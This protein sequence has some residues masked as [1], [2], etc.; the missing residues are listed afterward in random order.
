[1]FEKILLP[2]DGSAMAERSI[3]HA[4]E[5]AR[6][7]N[8]KILI[9][10]ILKSETSTES[11]V[12]T[13]PLNWQLHKAKTELYLHKT[14]NEMRLSLGLPELDAESD[15]ESRVTVTVLE[16]KVAEN[17]VDFAQKENIDLLIISSHGS[18]GLSRWNL[19]SVTTKVVNL[20]YK[21]VLIIRG[22]A[23]DGDD[24]IHPRYERIML[25]LDCSR[26][27]E[28]SLNAGL[29]L[30]KNYQ[31]RVILSSV[32]KPPEIS[33]IDPYNQELQLLNQQYMDLSRK[34]VQS[35]MD[36]LSQRLGVGNEIRIV[37]DH[38]IVRAIMR[39]ADDENVDL[40]ILCAHGFTG[41]LSWPF[42][43]VARS[44][45]EYSTK[46]V[47]VIQD[48]TH[49]DVLPTDASQAIESTRSPE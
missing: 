19:N 39:L 7:F 29:T 17:I 33:A 18:S 16:G 13:E 34:T 40:L 46:P 15:G 44:F 24:P 1:M 38:S 42:G 26:R 30:A 10:Q 43:T 6:I 45:I 22:Y 37:E 48:L 9:L 4:I 28:C 2:L 5:F 35:Y 36:E 3:P 49:L 27:S 20:I 8:S 41:E 32:I 25:P 12:H 47:L 21:P 23:V 11:I 14:A 31:S